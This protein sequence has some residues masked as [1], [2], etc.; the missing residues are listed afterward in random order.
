[1]FYLEGAGWVTLQDKANQL[2]ICW[3]LI[4]GESYFLWNIKNCWT[5]KKNYIFMLFKL[6][7]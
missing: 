3:L 1:M 2:F 5:I 7:E 4:W 6:I